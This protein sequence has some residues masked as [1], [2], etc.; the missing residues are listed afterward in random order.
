MEIVLHYKFVKISSVE[1][2]ELIY[3]LYTFINN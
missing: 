2:K 1:N 3:V